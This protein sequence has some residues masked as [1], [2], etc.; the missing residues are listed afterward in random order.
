MP[1][2]TEIA[3]E[4]EALP[5]NGSQ[6]GPGHQGPA[7]PEAD[8]TQ[9]A[10]E[11][12]PEASSPTGTKASALPRED[13]RRR[14]AERLAGLADKTATR[15]KLVTAS[16]VAAGKTSLAK[17]AKIGREAVL[18]EIGRTHAKLRERTR[19]ERLARD[20]RAFLLWLHENVLDQAIERLFF[21]PTKGRVALETLTVRGNN[22]A[23]G[24]DYCPSPYFVF[25][26]ALSAIV[27]DLS[28]LSFVDYGAGKGRVLLL[29]S[30]HPFTAVGGI[31]FAEEL[32]DDAIMNIAQ[33]PRSRMKCR[34]VECVLDDVVNIASPEGEAIH[35]F[36]NPFAPEIFAQVLNAIVASYH[37]RPRR[38][39]LILIDM[40][41]DELMYMTGV[42]QEVKL[43]MAE[44]VQARLLSPYKIN[45]YR[46]L[47]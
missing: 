43:P 45:V 25:R 41:A 40:N 35:Y 30:Q 34:D 20:Y 3:D 36:F 33:F 24:H 14:V 2:E 8:V 4:P 11:G 38:L 9:P 42:F 7:R 21:V 26:W 18:P 37:A 28:R 12:A 29:A 32:H 44:H 1:V 39:Y 47:A 17:A 19:P 15:T 27:D 31:E 10:R 13:A 5:E 16:A 6:I 46:S 22:R 23:S